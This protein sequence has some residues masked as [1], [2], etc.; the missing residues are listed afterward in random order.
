M[1][2]NLLKNSTLS[3]RGFIKAA[4]AFCGAAALNGFTV[5][6]PRAQ[7]AAIRV[8]Y[9]DQLTGPGS[10]FAEA[11]PWVLEQ[12][13]K[14]VENG[15]DI[16]GTNYPVEIL[17]RDTQSN[18]NRVGS[19]GNDLLVRENVHLFLSCDGQCAPALEICDQVGTPSITT[20]FQWEPFYA[21]RGGTPETGYPWSFLFFWS[22]SEIITNYIDMWESSGIEKVV[23]TVYIDND[24]AR[25]FSEGL[26]AALATA[27][28]TEVKGGLV[29]PET[30]DFSNQVAAFRD[31]GV[32]I[33]SGF[34]F[35]NH[36]AT[37][38]GQGKQAGLQVEAATIAGVF[39]FPGSIE[40][41]GADGAGMS[42]EVWFNR[43]LPFKSS[44]TGQTAAE[45]CDAYSTESG[46]QWTQPMGYS[47]ALWEVAIAA[48]KASGD[49]F[50]RAK[51]RDAIAGL[52]IETIVGPV[53]FAGSPLKS[54][55][56]TWITMGQWYPAEGEHPFEVMVTNNKTAP[57]ISIQAPF[58]RLSEFS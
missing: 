24:F 40:L 52:N 56:S 19:L 15:I 23:G 39:T 11:A 36:F 6:N 38:W 3:R 29:R 46:K 10:A 44:L 13:G 55:A 18:P 47:H 48:L 37:F 58:K 12:I 51:V 53:D 1:T 33:V 7:G 31:A 49:P 21:A 4:G 16:G 20:M 35:P 9:I 5:A 27:G 17:V 26:S 50:D 45:L 34:L 30:D 2:E 43:E 25:S 8:G 28:F 57:Q 14:I 32:K 54:V 41:L 42:T 22:G